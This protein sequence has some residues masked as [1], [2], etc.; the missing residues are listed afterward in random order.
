MQ[1]VALEGRP[2]VFVE[3]QSFR[4]MLEGVEREK[5]ELR[6]IAA[7]AAAGK[8]FHEARADEMQREAQALAW[9]SVWGPVLGAGIGAAAIGVLWGVVEG[10]KAGFAAKENR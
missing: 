7:K 2:G 3:M 9:R 5:G 10:I 4:E 1:L 6:N 8:Q